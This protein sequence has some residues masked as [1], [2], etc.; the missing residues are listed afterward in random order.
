M[1][2]LPPFRFYTLLNISGMA[3][4]RVVKFCVVVG[5]IKCKLPGKTVPGRDVVR[6]T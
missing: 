1:V 4:A 2:T 5:Y 6:V 3:E